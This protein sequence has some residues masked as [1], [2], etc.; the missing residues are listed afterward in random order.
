MSVC[1]HKKIVLIGGGNIDYSTGDSLKKI[2]CG[3]CGCSMTRKI[4]PS[5]SSEYIY[6]EVSDND[7]S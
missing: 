3:Q 7:L 5:F 4:D 6:V 1:K 2:I